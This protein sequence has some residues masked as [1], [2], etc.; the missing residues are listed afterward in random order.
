MLRRRSLLAAVTLTVAGAAGLAPPAAAADVTCQT[1]PDGTAVCT[2]ATTAENGAQA[3]FRYEVPADWNGTLLVWSRGGPVPTPPM[4]G[5]DN[6]RATLLDQGYALLASTYSRFGWAVE[7]GPADQMAALDAFTTGVGTPERTIA[8]GGSL[9]GVITGAIVERYPDRIDGAIPLCHG[10]GGTTAQWNQLLD[11]TFVVDEL[12]ATEDDLDL[13]DLP[14]FP[15]PTPPDAAAAAALLQE[16]QAT[17]EG[18]ARIALAAAMNNAPLWVDPADPEP[19][20]HDLA[21]QQAQLHDALQNAVRLGMGVPRQELEYRAGGNFSWN[22]GV[23][24]REQLQR[25]GHRQLVER[26]YRAAGL[27]LRDDLDRLAAAPRIGADPEAVAYAKA[28]L[29]PSGE[30]SIPVLTM[31]TT[32]DA[33]ALASHSR[34]YEDVVRRAGNAQ[35][36]RT[37]YVHGPGHCT[38]T[39]A[40]HLA[41]L[42]TMEHRLDT[43][44]WGDAATPRAMN[45]LATESGVAGPARFVRVTPERLLRPCNAG[46]E[47]PGQP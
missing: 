21:A 11:A 13:V 9:G 20:R 8:W 17:P 2:G 16:A 44:R 6:L 24:Y 46:E 41:A 42:R 30:I 15:G 5:P 10:L 37:A 43:G 29:A 14:P 1:Q 34:T 38:F 18:R 26:L 23:D 12:I 33:S 31:N 47:C 35:L 22:V 19:G 25:S 4:P 36:L 32:G 39:A 7:E 40:E 45:R 3:P 27:D 28:N